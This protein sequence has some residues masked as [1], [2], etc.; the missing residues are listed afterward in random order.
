MRLLTWPLA[1]CTA[2]YPFVFVPRSFSRWSE[3]TRTAVLAHEEAHHRQQKVMGLWRFGWRYYLDR[4]FRWRVESWGY[5]REFWVYLKLGYSPDPTYYARV[6]SGKLY[7]FMVSYDEALT[8]TERTLQHL[9][10]AGCKAP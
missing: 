8:W 2:I 7:G 9:K 10:N 5:R 1:F 4:R 3:I 6:L